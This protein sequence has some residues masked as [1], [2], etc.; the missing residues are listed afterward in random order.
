MSVSFVKGHTSVH[1]YFTLLENG[2]LTRC[3]LAFLWAWALYDCLL[4]EL[5]HLECA[6]YECAFEFTPQLPAASWPLF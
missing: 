4:S 6:A 5:K 3:P 1:C 2:K